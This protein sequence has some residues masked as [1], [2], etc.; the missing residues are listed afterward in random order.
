[1]AESVEQVLQKISFIEKDIELHKKILFTLKPEQKAEMEETMKKIVAMNERVDE[2]K[3]S[4]AELDPTVHQQILKLEE[5]TRNFQELAR[6]RDL[7][8]VITL[9]QVGECRI[10]L[11]DGRQFECLVKAIDSSG[12]WLGLTHE[13]DVIEFSQEEVME[14]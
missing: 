5:G 2:L 12:N 6:G 8:T 3:S 11:V 1:M 13:G 4:I 14:L 7:Q 9:D 10:D